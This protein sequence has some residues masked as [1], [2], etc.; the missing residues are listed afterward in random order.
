MKEEED[1]EEHVARLSA[2]HKLHRA[3][4]K[5]NAA[6]ALAHGAQRKKKRRKMTVSSTLGA[7][8]H[9][10]DAEREARKRARRR[11]QA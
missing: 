2:K 1:Q 5:L 8:E 11:H 9:G 7:T 4:Q 6:D 10:G 3:M